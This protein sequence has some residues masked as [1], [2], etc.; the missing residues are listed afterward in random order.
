MK[1][2]EINVKF[3]EKVAEYLSKGYI[4]NTQSMGGSQGEIGKV[5]LVRGNQLIRIWLDQETSYYTRP[6]QF[7]GNMIVLRVSEWKY[8]AGNAMYFD[9]TVWMSDLNHIE[10]HLFYQINDRNKWYIEDLDEAI[11]CQGISHE[12][13]YARN[14]NS[15]DFVTTD[16]MKEIGAKYLKRVAGYKRVRKNEIKMMKNGNK[17]NLMYMGNNYKI[18]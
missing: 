6:G 3:S 17:Y 8:P 10:T 14:Y 12:R 16:A 15:N 1:F 18:K 4:I 11:R 9:S 5:D 7:T 2:H 13:Y